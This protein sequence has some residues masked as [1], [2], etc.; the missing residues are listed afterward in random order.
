MDG[1]FHRIA[2][3][4]CR[5]SSSHTTALDEQSYGTEHLKVAIR[6]NNLAQ[7][8]KT[9]NR[10][11]EAEALMGRALATFQASYGDEHSQTQIARRN[12]EALLE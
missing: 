7:L 11:A 4:Q 10:L 1:R 6:L 3:D 5:T 12:L 9:A 2:F 8:L